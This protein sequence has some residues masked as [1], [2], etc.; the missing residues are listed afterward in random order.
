MRQAIFI[1]IVALVSS[2]AYAASLFPCPDCEQPVSPRAVLCPNCGCPGQAIKDAVA[3]QEAAQRPPPIYPVAKLKAGNAPGTAIAYTDGE[4]RYLLIDAYPLMGAT[5]LQL[6]PITTNAP[7]P[8]HTMQV[9]AEAPLVRFQTTATNL[10]FLTRAALRT[11]RVKGPMWLHLDGTSAPRT[12]APNP[13]QSAVALLDS[14][15]NLVSVI[16]RGPD[17]IP[18]HVPFSVTWIDIAPGQFRNQTA[19]LLA[20][21]RAATQQSLGPEKAKELKDTQWATPFFKRTAE[22]IIKL[23]E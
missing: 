23:S 15:T 6:T 18:M 4:N 20:A 3:A 19:S 11:G 22:K 16:G 2:I 13:P 7:V 14:H 8:Y 9:A 1:T 10:V 5:S 21:T 12:A 17:V